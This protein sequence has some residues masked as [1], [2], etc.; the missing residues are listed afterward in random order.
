MADALKEE[1]KTKHNLHRLD[2]AVEKER[3]WGMETFGDCAA[4]FRDETTRNRQ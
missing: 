4:D 3:E 2:P 1:A